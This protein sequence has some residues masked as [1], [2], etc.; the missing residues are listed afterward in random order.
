MIKNSNFHTTTLSKTQTPHMNYNKKIMTETLIQ[1]DMSIHSVIKSSSIPQSSKLPSGRNR[2][3]IMGIFLALQRNNK[4]SVLF[5]LFKI[6]LVE[7]QKYK[8]V[9]ILSINTRLLMLML[10]IINNENLS[11]LLIWLP[12]QWSWIEKF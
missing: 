8:L 3:I 12:C 1:C 9:K 5:L 4:R 2:R 11:I 10:I 7:R 6:K